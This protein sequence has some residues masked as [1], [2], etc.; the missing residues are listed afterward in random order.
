MAK[1]NYAK[2][3]ADIAEIVG[4]VKTVPEPLQ[5]R[6]FEL[7][8]DAVFSNAKA[9]DEPKPEQEPESA[10]NGKL[11]PTTDKKLP[12]NVLAFAHRHRVTK[13]ELAKLFMLDHDPLRPIYRILSD[14][15]AKSQINKVMMVLLENGL[16]TNAL[17][18]PYGELREAVRD[19]GLYNANFNKT[20]KRNHSLFRGAIGEDSID[21]NGVVELTGGGMEKLAE[22][23]RE[24]GQ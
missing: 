22:V 19:D 23:I 14:N 8:F 10:A 11:P 24:L 3:K 2:A 5:Q 1:L 18:A 7:L 15:V 20:L 12:P 21:E 17:T 4:I 16:L 13:D 9:A 6:C